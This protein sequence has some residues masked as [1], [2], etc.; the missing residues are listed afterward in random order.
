MGMW[1]GPVA[2]WRVE[3]PSA[4]HASALLMLMRR[5]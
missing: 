3:P 4:V 1:N 2:A 5:F